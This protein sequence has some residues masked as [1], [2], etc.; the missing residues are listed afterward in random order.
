MLTSD[1]ATRR[2]SAATSATTGLAVSRAPERHGTAHVEVLRR[3]SAAADRRGRRL[4]H[5]SPSRAHCAR[6]SAASASSIA[7][8]Q[9][10]SPVGLPPEC[11]PAPVR[12]GRDRRHRRSYEQ[13]PEYASR[14][15]ASAI[16]DRAVDGGRREVQQRR[17]RDRVRVAERDRVHFG[18]DPGRG[19]PVHRF[20]RHAEG[21]PARVRAGRARR[22]AGTAA[23][24]PRVRRSRTRSR[25]RRW[26]RCGAACSVF[27]RCTSKGSAVR[28]RSGSGSRAS[29]SAVAR[30]GGP[31]TMRGLRHEAAGWSRRSGS[32]CR[33]RSAPARPPRS[34]RSS[35]RTRETGRPDRQ[36]RVE[37]GVPAIEVVAV[38]AAV[39]AAVV[40]REAHL[41]AQVAAARPGPP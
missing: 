28:R 8:S 16:V 12:A 36:E 33:D 30:I 38:R 25:R 26:I 31:G 19:D 5:R 7:C 2:V 21:E 14:P 6:A 1:S 37:R 9:A 3:A 39:Q 15:A 32:G 10:S 20:G 40:H 22:A 23:R 41:V 13:L 35:P 29:I 17:A 24:S 27:T 11:Q 4:R 18:P 34:A